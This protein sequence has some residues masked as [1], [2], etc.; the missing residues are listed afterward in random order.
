V[1]NSIITLIR[2]GKVDGP[3]ALYGHTDIAMSEAGAAE[4]LCNIRHIHQQNPITHL[5]NSP[6]IRCAIPAQ[7]F[8][9][10][11]ELPLAIVDDLKEMH[12]GE[13]DGIPFE[14]FDEKR[15]QLLTHFWELPSKAH[16]PDGESLQA[17][18][19]RIIACWK[20]IAANNHAAHQLVICHGGVIRIVIAYLL[21]LDWRNAS[22]FRQLNIDYASHT[23]IEL[24][25]Y[26]NASPVIKYIG[27]TAPKS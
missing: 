7:E 3:A 9:R 19:E 27:M 16:A 8:A 17:F 26:E 4:L 25:I 11:Y 14:Q 18:A 20:K 2:H 24:P 6:L 10:H 15:W 5:V 22:L 1:S 13:W 21:D 23:R 12:F